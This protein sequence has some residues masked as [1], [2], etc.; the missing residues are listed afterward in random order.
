[1]P[2]YDDLG[3]TLLMSTGYFKHCRVLQVL[4]CVS[5][6]SEGIPALNI[7]TLPFGPVPELIVLVENMVLVLHYSRWNIKA[8]DKMTY[9]F[10]SIE[11]GDTD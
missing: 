8:F 1:M 7:D 9:T 10:L 5:T 2:A 6:A 3:S 11:V 4:L